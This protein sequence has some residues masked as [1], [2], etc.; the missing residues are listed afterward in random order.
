MNEF[1]T[2]NDVIDFAISE[3]EGAASFYRS[4]AETAEKPMM[5]K[6]FIDFAVEEEGHKAKLESIK[7]GTEI[8][9]AAENIVDLKIGDYMPDV[10]P[11][12]EMNYQEALIM[13]MK[14]EK[15]AFRLYQDLANIS[16]DENLKQ[17]FFALAQEEAKHKLRFELEYDEHYLSEG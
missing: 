8:Q 16:S 13:A 4:L 11:S 2:I 5:K 3:E 15:A 14:K 7:Q 6:I 17:I 1:K 10:M 12:P 9:A